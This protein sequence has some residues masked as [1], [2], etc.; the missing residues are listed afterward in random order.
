MSAE[1]V[2]RWSVVLGIVVT[3]ILLRKIFLQAQPITPAASDDPTER[4][5]EFL[6][7]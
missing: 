7:I 2:T 5:E 3:T 6:G 4:D 1:Q